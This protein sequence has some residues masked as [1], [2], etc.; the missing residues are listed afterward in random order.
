M[1]TLVLLRHGQSQWN[2]ENRFTGFH[3]IDLSD[4]GREEARQAGLRLKSAGIKFDQVFT[5]TLQRAYH[6][7]EIA[8]ENAGQADLLNTM[9]RHD[10]L[11]E[12]D[13]G[14]LTG[15]NKDET[16]AKFG[17]EQVH[18]WRRS[19]DVN[20]PGGESLQDVVEN[21]VRPY[22]TANIKP[23]VDGGKNV[24]IAA[25]GNSLRGILIVLGAETPD[26]INAAE[27]ETG[28]PLVFELENGKILRRY[29]LK[30]ALAA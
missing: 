4:L 20:P 9:I 23:L 25:H 8:L 15:L 5:S 24:L 27:M 28:V 10:D 26:T 29:A 12:R 30:D 3:D 19:Y 22:Y 2:L 18:I 11:R 7:A 17:D 1:N 14:D 16:R 6:T 13:Y 21:R